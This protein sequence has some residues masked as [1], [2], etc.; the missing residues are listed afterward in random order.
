MIHASTFENNLLDFVTAVIM[1]P[2]NFVYGLLWLLWLGC[3]LLWPYR[4]Y[5][6]KGAALAAT[7][8]LLVACPALALGLVT[9]MAYG[10]FTYPMH[11]AVGA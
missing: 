11:K 1:L 5:I 2:V 4:R 6:A 9:I 7:A 10:L 3:K 8:A